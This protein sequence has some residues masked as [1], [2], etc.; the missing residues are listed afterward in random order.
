MRIGFVA[1][2]A[3]TSPVP[4]NQD[5][6][7]RFDTTRWSMVLRARGGPV[8]ARAALDTLCRRYRPPVL[9]YVRRRGYSSENAEDLAQTFFARFIELAY[10][11]DADP[12]RGRFRAFLLTALKRF[13]IDADAASHATK[14]GGQINFKSLDY[15]ANSGD[16]LQ[17]L[18]DSQTPENAFERDWAA[19]V[20]ESAMFRLRHEAT[21]AGKQKLFDHL[22][23]FLLERPDEADYVRVASELNLRRNTLAVAVHRLRHRLRELVR[24]ELAETTADSGELEAEMR[25][26]RAALNNVMA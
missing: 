20:L 1:V 15:Q 6:M 24:E 14:R 21:D 25:Q 8:E 9:A 2:S 18:A 26:L 3:H 13:L 22:S 7:T 19:T 10:H 17:H 4:G 12:A 11:A 23:E 16:S 5:T